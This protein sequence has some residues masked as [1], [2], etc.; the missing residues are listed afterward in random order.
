MNDKDIILKAMISN[1][2]RAPNTFYTPHSLKEHLFPN[3]NTDQVE[4]II[5]QIINEK[6]ELIK[7]EKVSSAPFAI[8]PTG[9]VESFLANGG[10]TKIDQDLETELIKRTERE[11]KVDKLMDLDLKLKQFESRIGR[12]IVIA[13]III[14]ILNLLISIIG[15]EFRSSENKQPIETPQ[16]DKRQPIETKTNVEDSLN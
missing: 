1:P 6:Q 5:K 10:F 11:V 8:S 16:S 15:F 13:G 4:F 2:N 14:T 9:I 3:H 12:K 7:I